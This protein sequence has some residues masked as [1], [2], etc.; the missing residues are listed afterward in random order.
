MPTVH[1]ENDSNR[2]PVIK[3]RILENEF[4]NMFPDLIKAIQ[5]DS[6]FKCSE[7]TQNWVSELLQYNVPHG[8]LARSV[9][10]LFP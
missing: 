3:P 2:T 1:N 6:A 7:S 9:K 10:I 4:R 5:E 8:K